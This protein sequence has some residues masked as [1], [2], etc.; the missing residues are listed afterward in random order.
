MVL[1]GLLARLLVG[2]EAA[3]EQKRLRVPER[4]RFLKVTLVLY[5]AAANIKRA[6][7]AASC[8]DH[9]YISQLNML[10]CFKGHYT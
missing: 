9:V 3:C 5:V 1:A 6:W 4:T 7:A 8:N 10:R 2:T